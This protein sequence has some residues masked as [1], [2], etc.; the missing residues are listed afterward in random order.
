MFIS[1]FI[2]VFGWVNCLVLAASDLAQLIDVRRTRSAPLALSERAIYG[3]PGAKFPTAVIKRDTVIANSTSLE[4]LGEELEWRCSFHLVSNLYYGHSSQK[5]TVYLL[6][7]IEKDGVDSASI[8]VTCT[9]CY[10]KGTG[11]AQITIDENFNATEAFQNFTFN[12]ETDVDDLVTELVDDAENYVKQAFTS[13]DSLSGDDLNNFTIP[14]DLWIDLPDIPECL[15][16]V[17]LDG[18][19]VYAELN[20]TL[21][22]GGTYGI[23]L[24]STEQP[25]SVPIGNDTQVGISFTVDLILSTEDEIDISSGFHIMLNDGAAINIPMFNKTVSEITL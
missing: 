15:L 3:F 12:I 20:T 11:T 22:A 24:F 14:S 16:S 7:T 5:L 2:S 17:Q 6:S 21:S 23:N 9:T 13:L 18:L 8:E 19:E 10:I 1:R 25:L 4:L